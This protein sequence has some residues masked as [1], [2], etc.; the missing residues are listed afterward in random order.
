MAPMCACRGASVQPV[1]GNINKRGGEKT[2][3]CANASADADA[4]AER[5]GNQ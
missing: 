1:N 2:R 4:D 5:K 3:K